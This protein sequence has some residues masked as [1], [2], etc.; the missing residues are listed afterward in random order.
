MITWACRVYLIQLS[1]H[2]LVC[3]WQIRRLDYY[4]DFRCSAR[5]MC[6]LDAAFQHPFAHNMMLIGATIYKS[7]V[8]IRLFPSS[9]TTSCRAS[10]ESPLGSTTAAT[11]QLQGANSIDPKHT[12]GG[13]DA[14]CG[15]LDAMASGQ[16]LPRSEVPAVGG[17]PFGPATQDSDTASSSQGKPGGGWSKTSARAEVWFIVCM[18]F[19]LNAVIMPAQQILTVQGCHNEISGKKQSAGVIFK[20]LLL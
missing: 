3:I 15:C 19:L 1:N 18:P 8:P 14:I 17:A 9:W 16:S 10:A 2:D 12:L 7:F 6:Y 4:V 11:V 5:R 20:G 13:R